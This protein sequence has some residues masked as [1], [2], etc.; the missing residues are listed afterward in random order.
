MPFDPSQMSD[1]ELDEA[2]RQSKPF[3]ATQ[4]S[5]AEIEEALKG[6]AAPPDWLADVGKSAASGAVHGGIGSLVGLPGDLQAGAKALGNKAVTA[7]GG[8]PTPTRESEK[9]PTSED[10]AK[11]IGKLGYEEYTPKYAVGRIAK[12]AATNLVPALAG[13]EA[14][15][16]DI[17]KLALSGLRYGLAPA[18][19]GEGA[20]QVSEKL[21]GPDEGVQ[22]A[23]R[24]AGTVAGPRVAGKV[25]TPR[26]MGKYPVGKTPNPGETFGDA[27]S[28]LIGYP[29]GA[30][31]AHYLGLTGSEAP[32]ALTLA[33]PYAV[34]LARKQA[35]DFAQRA[36][37]SLT[38]PQIVKNY[39][40]NTVVPRK[41]SFKADPLLWS[42]ALR[43]YQRPAT[44]E[45]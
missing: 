5:D 41:F 39:L 21:L 43:D 6:T 37:E 24:L 23:A 18:A 20:T 19:L 28:H 31:A 4:M 9:L 42:Q 25:I 14:L 34:N 35:G 10:I 1:K 3:D 38:S 36:A 26:N 7:M 11:G 12:G 13:P 16:G 40:N 2:I 33:G 45:E 8:V 22:A 30:A 17:G 29:A 44:P 15:T 27:M 32:L